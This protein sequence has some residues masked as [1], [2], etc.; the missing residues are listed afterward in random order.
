MSRVPITVVK[1]GGRPAEDDRL[2]SSIARE[3]CIL[4]DGGNRLLLVHGG[5]ITISDLQGKYGLKP[6][7]KDG[8]RQTSPEEM[9][10]VDMA[11][12][13][14][15]NKRLVRLL[16]N[17]NVN[18][19]GL[20]GADGGIIRAESATGSPAENR[21]GT[22]EAVDTRALGLLWDGGYVPVF[23]PPATDSTGLGININ[24]DEAALALSVASGADQLIFI[25]DVPGVLE[26]SKI[27][28]YLTPDLIEEKVKTGVITGGMIP[29]VRSAA[30][31]VGQDVGSVF[32]ADYSKFGDLADIISGKRG[33]LINSGV[34]Q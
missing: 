34:A 14:G 31:A 33:T 12:A 22:V 23:A 17:E 30:G 26:E 24:A 21:T 8:L 15:V 28:G 25:S 10:M 27:I 6:R 7:F 9:P 3:I 4:Q 20:S 2:I 11:L 13:G 18:A 32:I 29:K 16:R 19:W 1:I 5:G